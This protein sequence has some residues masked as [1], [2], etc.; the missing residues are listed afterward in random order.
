M[1]HYLRIL[2]IF[3]MCLT[4]CG[5]AG[6][7]KALAANEIVLNSDQSQILNLSKAPSTIL[8]GNPSVADVTINGTSLYLHPRGYGVTNL[9]VLDEA[10]TKMGDYV[11][12]VVYEDPY[13]VSMY[14]PSGRQT[15][16]CRKDCEPTLQ[17]G[18]EQ[19]HFSNYQSQ[20]RGKTGFAT[21]Q[22]LGDR[23]GYWGY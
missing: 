16:S 2:A 20:V 7:G 5:V 22:A 3:A 13:S 11:L 10:G 9:I 12:R 19:Q 17:V 23:W 1:R 21:S 15:Y 8:L 18:D 4:G 14:S 6:A